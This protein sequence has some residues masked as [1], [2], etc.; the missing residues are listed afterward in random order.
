MR[1]QQV[2][3]RHHYIKL[4]QL[5]QFQQHQHREHQHFVVRAEAGPT[6]N[7]HAD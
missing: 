5:G 1:Q 7:W 6:G 3:D 2:V 4:E